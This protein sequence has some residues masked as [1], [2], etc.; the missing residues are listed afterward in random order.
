MTMRVLVEFTAQRGQGEEFAAGFQRIVG[1][2]KANDAGCEM[3]DL[4]R[5][6]DDPD[7][8]ALVEKWTTAADLD[9][10][11]EAQRSRGSSS[12]TGLLA[13]PPAVHRFQEA[14]A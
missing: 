14:S 10:H 7:R 13:E 11:S 1:E 2:V 9:A 6:L 4:F 5:S 12:A 8:F 3:Y